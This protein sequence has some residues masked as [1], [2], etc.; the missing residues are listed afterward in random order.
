MRIGL[1]ALAVLGMTTGLALAHGDRPQ[2]DGHHH[3]LR[4]VPTVTL[5]ATGAGRFAALVSP[6]LLSY[7]AAATAA[8]RQAAD[9]CK[10]DFGS[11][12]ITVSRG[13][14]FSDSDLESWSFRVRCG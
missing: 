10:A 14:R 3:D 12:R 11:D 8:G 5:S 1:S 13:K 6:N 9:R 7:Q 4:V 2:G